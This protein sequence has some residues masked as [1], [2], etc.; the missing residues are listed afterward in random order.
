MQN[1]KDDLGTSDACENYFPPFL[2]LKCQNQKYLIYKR[3]FGFAFIKN[4]M[5]H[6]VSR[7]AKF[8]PS[9]LYFP[10]DP[11]VHAFRNKS[12]QDTNKAAHLWPLPSRL[13][14]P[15]DFLHG[16]PAGILVCPGHEYRL[17]VLYQS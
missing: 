15:L 2:I 7:E 14:P 4:N 8:W 5:K 16:L 6:N 3:I 10:F 9:G 11:Y 12:E 17:D 1:L 13:C